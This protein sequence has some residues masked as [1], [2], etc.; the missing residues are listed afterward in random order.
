[1]GNICKLDT[2]NIH[3]VDMRYLLYLATCEMT[4]RQLLKKNTSAKGKCIYPSLRWPPRNKMSAKNRYFTTNFI[5]LN[6]QHIPFPISVTVSIFTVSAV[7]FLTL[8]PNIPSSSLPFGQHI[9]VVTAVSVIHCTGCTAL[10]KT[11]HGHFWW[12]VLPGCC[13]LHWL[14]VVYK[15]T[16]TPEDSQFSLQVLVL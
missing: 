15:L 16:W 10:L 8:T 11:V 14:N 2:I 6:T 1:M 3:A 13:D 4:L 7:I 9:I 12:D 5:H